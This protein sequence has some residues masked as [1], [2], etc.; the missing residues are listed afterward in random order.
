MSGTSL[1]GTLNRV[2]HL[3]KRNDEKCQTWFK[4]TL[5]SIRHLFKRKRKKSH[6]LI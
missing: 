4:G 6:T 3:F 2:R 5:N 1:K